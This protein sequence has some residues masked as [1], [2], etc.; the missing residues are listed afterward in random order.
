MKELD[1]KSNFLT[2]PEAIRELEKSEMVKLTD[3]TVIRR[4]QL[5]PGRE[6]VKK[7]AGKGLISAL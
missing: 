4:D 3:K 7:D 5:S 1:N 2:V 6:A